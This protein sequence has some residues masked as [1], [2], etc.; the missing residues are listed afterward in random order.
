[1]GGGNDE[2]P[3][4]ADEDTTETNGVDNEVGT[5]GAG[6]VTT[7]DE[8][9]DDDVRLGVAGFDGCI[10]LDGLRDDEELD[11]LGEPEATIGTYRI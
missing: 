2:Y 9:L 1:M 7:K 8:E 10:G 4:G 3:D 11:E 5:G 6:D